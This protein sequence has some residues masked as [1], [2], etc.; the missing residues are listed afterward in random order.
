MYKSKQAKI[1]SS[2]GDSKLVEQGCYTYLDHVR[3]VEIEYLSI[4]LILVVS[5]FKKVFHNDLPS[6]SP[7]RDIDLCT[8]LERIFIPFPSFHIEWLHQN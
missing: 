6:M 3:E 1:I 8:N 4:E 5:K 2:I 7:D